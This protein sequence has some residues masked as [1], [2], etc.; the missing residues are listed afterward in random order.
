M[1]GLQKRSQPCHWSFRSTLPCRSQ[2]RQT[3]NLTATN[4]SSSASADSD[5][6]QSF[7]A[8]DGKYLN[9][10]PVIIFSPLTLLLLMGV[11]SPGLCDTSSQL[12]R[13]MLYPTC[14]TCIN[15]YCQDGVELHFVQS[16]SSPTRYAKC[17]KLIKIW[18]QFPG[19]FLC[20]ENTS[21]ENV[22]TK[23]G[24]CKCCSYCGL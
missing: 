8:T 24:L 19:V 6:R 9:P 17:C 14:P 1:I 2:G 13:M 20:F 4:F 7:K 16:D 22:I 11:S 12:T 23:T 5:V 10:Q 21:G 3:I 18:K 15:I